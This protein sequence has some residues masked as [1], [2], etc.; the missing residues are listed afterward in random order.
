VALGVDGNDLLVGA[1]GGH[2]LEFGNAYLLDVRTGEIRRK[3]HGRGRGSSFGAAVAVQRNRVLIGAPE[4]YA[5]KR[6]RGRTYLLDKSGEV[7][8]IVRPARS[9]G[10]EVY[11]G[12]QVAFVGYGIGVVDEWNDP[13]RF[14]IIRVFR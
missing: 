12:R 2:R 4:W 3:Y 1:P 8:H 7:L 11:T 14:P 9:G 6:R 13:W 10:V 5:R